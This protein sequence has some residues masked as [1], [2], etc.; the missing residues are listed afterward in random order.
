MGNFHPLSL[1]NNDYKAFAKSLAMCLEKGISSLINLDQVDFIAGRHVAHNRRRL[2]HVMSE[3][4]DRVV[5][6]V[7]HT[8][9]VRF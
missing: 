2:F 3:A 6:S 5:L 8:V 7:S 4:R 9:K 1:L